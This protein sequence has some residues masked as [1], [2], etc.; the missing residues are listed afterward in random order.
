MKKSTKVLGV[1]AILVASTLVVSAG[2]L[3]FYGKVETTANVE[4]S[5]V[6]WDGSEWKEDNTAVSEDFDVTGGSCECFAHSILNRAEVEALIDIQESIN[7]YGKGPDGVDVEYIVGYWNVAGHTFP[8][9]DDYECDLEVPTTEYS[10]I[11]YVFNNNTA[12]EGDV[13]CVQSGTY[14]GFTVDVDGVTIVSNGATVEGQIKINANNVTIEGFEV[15]DAYDNA[16]WLMQGITGATIRNNYIHDTEDKINYEDSSTG[17]YLES[18]AMT[19]TVIEYNTIEYNFAGIGGTEDFVGEINYNV[20]KNNDEGIGVGYNGFSTYR[21]IFENNVAD[22]RV[23][24]NGLDPIDGKDN[25]Y[26][27]DGPVIDYKETTGSWVNAQHE[28][29]GPSF[30]LQPGEQLDFIIQYCFDIAIIPGTYDITTT[31]APAD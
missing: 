3:S 16:I 21:N 25:Y 28:T 8:S 15:I 18:G 6:L 20:I 12:K 7:A 22:F 30:T 26:G 10:D 23:Y 29:L 1:L 5:V 17:I 27:C 13:I 14:N 2:L 31:F 19:D 4:Q 9:L 24:V 11:Q